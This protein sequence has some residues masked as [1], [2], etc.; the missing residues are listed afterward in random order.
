MKKINIIAVSLPGD[1][2]SEALEIHRRNRFAVISA[3]SRGGYY[4]KE[5]EM[6]M[7]FDMHQIFLKRNLPKEKLMF[8]MSGLKK[9]K[10]EIKLHLLFG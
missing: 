10:I 6:L 2:Y 1:D 5:S 9:T 7:F 8:L 4:P 3:L